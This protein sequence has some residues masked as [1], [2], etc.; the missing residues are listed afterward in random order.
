MS[1]E[2]SVKGLDDFSRK[3]LTGQRPSDSG[4]S[5]VFM[6]R[7]QKLSDAAMKQYQE[8]RTTEFINRAGSFTEDLVAFVID[9]RKKRELSDFETIFGIALMTINFRSA[10]G[11]KQ[12]NEKE[13][14]KEDRQ[15]LLD[16]FDEICWGAQQYWDANQT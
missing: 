11:S 12:G 14:S 10:Y 13:P 7:G 2:T 15:K 4:T 3:F 6:T 9:Q 1:K 8:Q 5:E 16:T